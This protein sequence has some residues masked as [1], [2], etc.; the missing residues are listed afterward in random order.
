MTQ[1]KELYEKFFKEEFDLPDFSRFLF[2]LVVRDEHGAVIT[3]GGV[4]TIAESIIITDKDYPIEARLA[5]LK[6][7]Q[8]AQAY[9]A[10][11]VGYDQL[12]AF[13]QDEKW[14]THLKKHGF[15]DCIGKAL[16]LPL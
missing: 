14:L 1:L 10:Q 15:K 7:M 5:A 8:G 9:L 2:S 12:H 11:Q 4:R 16:Y 13:V 3:A 6:Q